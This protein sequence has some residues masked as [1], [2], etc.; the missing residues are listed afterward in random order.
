MNMLTSHTKFHPFFL[1]LIGDFCRPYQAA[2]TIGPTNFDIHMEQIESVNGIENHFSNYFNSGEKCQFP[3]WTRTHWT[4]NSTGALLSKK[5]RREA[6][7]REI[8]AATVHPGPYWNGFGE[9]ENRPKTG[10][11][12]NFLHYFH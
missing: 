7:T 3:D 5:D 2:I 9:A 10:I 4:M 6:A 11:Y 8:N 12:T 1:C